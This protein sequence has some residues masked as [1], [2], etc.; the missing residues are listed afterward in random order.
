MIRRLAV[1]NLRPDYVLLQKFGVSGKSIFDGKS[2]EA[3]QPVRLQEK[4]ALQQP[5][6]LRP[7][8][9]FGKIFR[10]VCLLN[11]RGHDS[12]PSRSPWQITVSSQLLTE[13]APPLLAF[14]FE[15]SMEPKVNETHLDLD[16][17]SGTGCSRWFPRKC[18]AKSGVS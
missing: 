4:R 6:K 18:R 7:N 12:A 16:K 2:K 14:S 5:V 15:G 10:C 11:H 8:L 17:N 9:L 13:L 1:I 3:P